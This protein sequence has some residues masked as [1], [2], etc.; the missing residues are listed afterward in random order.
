[1][2]PEKLRMGDGQVDGLGGE[3]QHRKVVGAQG[4][5]PKL[6]AGALVAL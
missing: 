6:R 4:H 1:V 3:F 2:S 5:V